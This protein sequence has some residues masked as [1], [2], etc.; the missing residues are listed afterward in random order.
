MMIRLMSLS[1]G[2]FREYSAGELKKRVLA[3]NQLCSKIIGIVLGTGLTCIVSL[4]YLRQIFVFA[5]RLVSTTLM[6]VGITAGMSVLITH[7]Q[8]KVN[9]RQMKLSAKES[10]M[11]YALISG[12]Q[13]IKLAGAEKRAFAKWMDSYANQAELQFNPPT[14][15][16][17]GRVIIIAIALAGN[18]VLY[19]M[20]SK[21]Q[22]EQ[23]NFFTFT[24][25]YGAL[26]G[27]FSA[28]SDILVDMAEIKPILE[29]A[30]PFL[31]AEP[32]TEDGG[33]ILTELS[34][35]IAIENVSFKYRDEDQYVFKNLSLTIQEGE[36]VA[37]VGK[38]GCGKST[39]IR[40]LLGF[41]KPKKGA[42]YFGDKNIN[43]I[44]MTSL[45]TKIGTVMQDS[46][47]FHGDIYSNIVLSAPELTI[48]D[49]WEAAEKAGIAEDIR[50]MP[51]GM[52]TVISEGNGSLS[53]GQKQRLMIA[54]AI[55]HKPKILLFD[56]A[57]SALDSKNQSQVVQTLG[58]MKGTRIVVA[59]RLSTI[60]ECDR[61]LVIDQG[62]IVEEGTY[63]ELIA[64]GGCFK[65][66]V[67]GQQL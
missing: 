4:L 59:H 30:K 45:R 29:M 8:S 12:I 58:Q 28:I 61:I 65:E 55:V 7:W 5:P 6:I 22:M 27:A 3:V 47:L 63:E 67:Q 14:V 25:V 46:G 18:I 40:L 43:Q 21:N 31:E 44:N 13:K 26:M 34:G 9:Q 50:K 11:S 19:Y 51:M 33:Q 48:E 56:E 60:R 62:R 35:K 52:Y 10:G 16:K 1:T 2:F 24:I 66:L 42:I 37:I 20:A 15:L 49:A 64:R 57:T 39:L 36:Y 38:T 17:L 23:S 41:E 54:R 32:E 53:G